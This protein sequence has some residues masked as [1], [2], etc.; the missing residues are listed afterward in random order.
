M[1]RHRLLVVVALF[2]FAWGCGASA[3]L[4]NPAG[5]QREAKV[6]QQ[7]DP[8][9][10]N[11][12]TLTASPPS[13]EPSGTPI[14]LAADAGC[15]PTPGS[16]YRFLYKPIG[17]ESCGHG[18]GCGPW[19]ELRGWGESTFTF[20][21]TGLVPGRYRLRAQGRTD[22][23]GNASRTI[24]YEFTEA[25]AP[26]YHSEGFDVCVDIDECLTGNGA[27]DPLVVCTNLP[28]TRS[29]GPCPP[30]PYTG[31]GD[32]ACMLPFVASELVGRP[33]DHSITINVMAGQVPAVEGGAGGYQALEV[34]F[35]YGTE[36]AE[37]G[38]YPGSTTPTSFAD[39]IIETV[40]SGL[41]ADT[42][43]YYRMRY[44]PSG[45]TAPFLAGSEHTFHTQR[46]AG[47]TFTFAVKSD[48]HQGYTSGQFWNE[49]L[50]QITME[51]IGDDQADFLVDLGDAVSTDDATETQASVRQKYL[52]QRT[53]H[54]IVGH[55]MPVFL[56]LGNH[57][58]EEG[59]NLDD[60][61][62]NRPRTRSRSS[63]RT[64]ASA[65]S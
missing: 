15:V 49:T 20:E 14:L 56:A 21:T 8:S 55:S 26:G 27:C 44:R 63:A 48:S 54:D 22:G 13:P 29:C 52:N 31:Q 43:Y 35:E 30:S 12:G 9:G 3:L 42:H 33:T 25:C 46:P 47:S 11:P 39:G 45:S 24:T 19:I 10:C 36:P 57:E 51:N 65:S 2:P 38:L 41:G 6:K 53:T 1:E 17:G 34:Y 64:R 60:M 7:T 32:T 23:E 37:P 18:D 62:T 50:Y 28:G 5:N 58:N 16:E 61:D 4:E 59:W 40:I